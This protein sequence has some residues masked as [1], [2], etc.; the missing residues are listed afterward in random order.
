MSLVLRHKPETIGLQLNENGWADVQE[1]ID[2]M[3]AT[4]ADVTLE[5]ID[6]IVETN[7]K[8]RFVFNE[9]KTMI[10]ANQGHSLDV[11]L[12]LKEVQPP[13]LL[14]HGTV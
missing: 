5:L 12:N 2:K 10:R 1:L 6:T 13:E 14:Y 3:N 11:E 4:G 8:K 7:D 9:D